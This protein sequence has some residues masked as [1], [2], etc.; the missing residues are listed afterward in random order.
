M[1]EKSKMHPS[2]SNLIIA[3]NRSNR[4]TV[5]FRASKMN[6][7]P[8]SSKNKL[9][10][11]VDHSALSDSSN[12]DDQDSNDRSISLRQRRILRKL[13]NDHMSLK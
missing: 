9:S 12:S 11:Q 7:N 4:Q 6:L 13:L 5:S 1:K 2:N 10:S 8:V 3:S